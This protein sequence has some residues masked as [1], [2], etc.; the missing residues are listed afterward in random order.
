MRNKNLILLVILSLL[1]IL[2][3]FSGEKHAITFDDFIKIKRIGD[4]QLSP[5]GKSVAFVITKMNKEENT[6]N[7]D[8]WLVSVDGKL[9]RKLTSSPKA[10][11][12]PRWSPDGKKIAFISTRNGSPQIWMINLK[13]GE[14]YQI[15]NVPTGV[16]EFIWSPDGKY[17]IYASKVY[18]D[19][20]DEKCNKEREEKKKKN[21]VK[22]KIF[23]SLLFRHWDEWRDEKRSHL[24][25]Y[26]ID[27]KKA[28]DLT[29]GNYDCPPIALGSAHDYDFSPD[30]KE[31][32]LVMNT[33]PVVAT[34]TNNDL[35]IVSLETKEI[36]RLTE[37]KANDN[38]PH[39]SPDG[40]Y[41]AYRAMKRPGFESDKYSLMIYERETGKTINL[42]EDFDLSI[43]NIVWSPDSKYIYFSCQEKARRPIYR[44]SIKKKKIEKILD[45]VTTGNFMLT[46]DGKTIIF[47][48]EAINLPK[49]IF[50]YDI[51]KKKIE[52]I[53]RIN[54]EILSKLEMNSL[55]EFWFTGANGDKVHG[56]LLK[57]PFFDPTKKYPL[58][59]LIHGG[60]QGAW[61]DEFHYRWNAQMFASPGYVVVM[62][63]FHGSTGYGQA[64]TDSITGDWGGKPFEDLMAGLTYVLANYD[65]IDPN[66]KAAAGASYG[67]YMIN[68][69]E[70]HTN[71]FKCLISHAGVFD[72]RSMYGATE[73]LWFPEWEFKG[74]PWTNPEMYEKFSPSYYVQYFKTPCLVI[75][76]QNDFRVP[77]TQGFQMFTS[78]QRMGVPSKLVY[79][80]DETHFVQKPKN[81][82]LWWK[83]VHEWL[84]KYLKPGK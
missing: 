50:K 2:P 64:F 18:P 39:Y 33:D 60:P 6:S 9:L 10:D 22:A 5:D 48:R 55:E 61:E 49:E 23:N 79:F 30:G 42:T 81:A 77:V 78:L 70:G 69:I 56:L 47:E 72:L 51:K 21:K 36:K 66:L 24:F 62:I 63:N 74:T 20:P 76:G 59:M 37:N 46:P 53:T 7:S 4:S 11:Y 32:C 17:L 41:I 14:A 28:V 57:P 25:L 8:I 45:G 75:H 19:C 43:G 52:Q 71:R 73:E 40:K 65:F 38:S 26:S 54:E 1:L 16:S 84:A 3:A 31:V 34:S 58:V 35:F 13:G 44:V 29:P 67:G 27:E 83:V 15:T 68:W 82:E 80:P 12:R